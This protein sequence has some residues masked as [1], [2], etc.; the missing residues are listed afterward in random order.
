M[1]LTKGFLSGSTL[2]IIAIVSM[3]VDHTAYVISLWSYHATLHYIMRSLIGRIAFPLFCFLLVEGFYHTKNVRTYWIRLGV[4]AL[5]SEIPYDL[6]FTG[7]PLNLAKQ[8]VFFTLWIGMLVLFLLE[9]LKKQKNLILKSGFSFLVIFSGCMTAWI[10]KSDYGYMGILLITGYYICSGNMAGN[11]VV[12]IVFNIFKEQIGGILS[13]PL[14]ALYNGKKGL[15]LKYIFYIFYP[16][17]LILL[18]LI[19][20]FMVKTVG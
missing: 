18:Y 14:I 19:D 13:L 15:R 1:S 2:K 11:M 3:L 6:L 17:H 20:W 7:Q 8:N 9:R 5:I 16:L 12:T 10:L 4:F